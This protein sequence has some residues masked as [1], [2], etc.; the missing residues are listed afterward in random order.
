VWRPA[1]GEGLLS[2]GRRTTHTSYPMSWKM[3]GSSAESRILMAFWGYAEPVLV[4]FVLGVGR[5]YADRVYKI[6]ANPRS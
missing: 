3:V 1:E 5:K 4:A 6:D 2:S